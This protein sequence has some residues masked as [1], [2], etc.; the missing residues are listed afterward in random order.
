MQ[1]TSMAMLILRTFIVLTIVLTDY[2]NFNVDLFRT[3]QIQ[4]DRSSLKKAD[5]D[6]DDLEKQIQ[7][8]YG[9]VLASTVAI[10][11]GATGV[12]VSEDGYILTAGHVGARTKKDEKINITMSD[13]AQYT[14]SFL[15]KDVKGDYTLLKIVEAGP[16]PY[17]ELGTSSLLAQDEALLMFGHSR[18][19]KPGRPALM[20]IGFYKGVKALGYLQTSCIMMPGDSGGPIVDLNGKLIGVC[21]HIGRPMDKNYYAPI[22][23]VKENW[24]KLVN[25]EVFNLKEPGVPPFPK[26]NDAT[27]SLIKDKPYALKG[28]KEYLKHSIE[29]SAKNIYKSVVKIQSQSKDSLIETYGT[30]ISAKGYIVAKASE[31]TANQI[32]CELYDGT[33]TSAKILSTDTSNDLVVLQTELKKLKSIKISKNREARVGT[34]VGTASFKNGIKYSGVISAPVRPIVSDPAP[35]GSLGVSLTFSNRIFAAL[36]NGA[37]K[38][39]GLKVGDTIVKFDNT[40]IE[41]SEQRYAFLSKT[42][43]NQKVTVTALRAGKEI[44]K[45]VTLLKEDPNRIRRRHIAFDIDISERSSGF[46]EAFS[47]DMPIEPYETGTPV[48]D[49]NGNVIGI[50]ISKRNRTTSFALPISVVQNIIKKSR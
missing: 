45:E 6:A 7:N 21:S 25:G 40:R 18:G 36:D 37:A 30:V 34:L 42:R 31:V 24:T 35:A 33:I 9:K 16:F 48:V 2:S 19:Y 8:I 1:N 39:G 38:L 15:G 41:D 46:T 43:V 22:D 27:P 28:G 32:R 47:H 26:N 20:R 11:N 12:L 13:G 50:N 23:A 29:Q 10:G 5:S 49:I 44:V 14:A 17:L 3:D 4:L